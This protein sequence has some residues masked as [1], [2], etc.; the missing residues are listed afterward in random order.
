[1]CGE[2]ASAAQRTD[3]R[4]RSAKDAALGVAEVALQLALADPLRQLL[5]R[6]LVARRVGEDDEACEQS[7]RAVWAMRGA[8]APWIFAS[9]AIRVW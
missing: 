1:M 5:A 2:P 3:E 4:L 6:L 9:M 8:H 7:A